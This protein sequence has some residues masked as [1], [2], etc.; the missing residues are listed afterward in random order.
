MELERWKTQ[1]RKGLLDLCV[2]NFLAAHEYYGY[3]LVQEMKEIDG[4][5]MREGT[6]YPILAR[7]EEDGLVRSERRPSDAGPPRKYFIITRAG[8][9]AVEEMNRHW[10]RIEAAVRTA[11]RPGTEGN[12]GE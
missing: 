11:R 6:I 10:R 7:L 4:L 1:L 2:L 9:R 8:E 3:D 12:H 5:Q